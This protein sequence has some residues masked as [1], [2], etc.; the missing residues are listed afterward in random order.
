[1]MGPDILALILALGLLCVAAV[2]CFWF[3]R[4]LVRSAWLLLLPPFWLFMRPRAYVLFLPL[5]FLAN[6]LDRLKKGR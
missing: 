1:M 5:F 2:V 6:W 3:V 4:S